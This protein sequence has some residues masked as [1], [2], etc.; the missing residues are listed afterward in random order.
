M[1]RK[2]P[3][4]SRIQGGMAIVPVSIARSIKTSDALAIWILA[5]SYPRPPVLTFEQ[6]RLQLSIGRIRYRKAMKA[7]FDTGLAARTW[8][9][10]DEDHLTKE[11]IVLQERIEVGEP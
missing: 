10:T 2:A 8:H 9:G 1:V 6:V 3:M 11:Y 7:L 5:A 4:R